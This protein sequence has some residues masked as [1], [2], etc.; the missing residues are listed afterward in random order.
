MGLEFS[1]IVR[2][3]TFSGALA[4]QGSTNATAT[5]TVTANIG[6]GQTVYFAIGQWGLSL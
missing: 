6:A 1:E 3:T 2:G 5:K 4:A